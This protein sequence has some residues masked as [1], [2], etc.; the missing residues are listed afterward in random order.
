MGFGCASIFADAE[1]DFA[2]GIGSVFVAEAD[3]WCFGLGRRRWERLRRLGWLR[4]FG[5]GGALVGRGL[6]VGG[7]GWCVGPIG[8]DDG[9]G[10]VGAREVGANGIR[11]ADA[12]GGEGAD[13]GDVDH[14]A[15]GGGDDVGSEWNRALGHWNRVPAETQES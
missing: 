7:C 11:A 15:E 9:G 1:P 3:A 8:E 2:V 10:G 13:G 4:G 6:V 12:G 5:V 14:D